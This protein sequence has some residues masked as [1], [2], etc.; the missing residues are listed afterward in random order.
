MQET[1]D[2]QQTKVKRRNKEQ[3]Q[4]VQENDKI[5]ITKKANEDADFAR[6]INEEVRTHEIL[7]AHIE[8]NALI[9]PTIAYLLALTC[10]T[11][12]S[13]AT[14]F[15]TITLPAH[16]AWDETHFG[17]HAN[18]YINGSFFFDVHPPLGKMLI[19]F[20]G[21]LTGYNASFSFKEPGLQ[22]DG[23]FY[24]PMRVFCVTLGTFLP[25]MVFETMFTLTSSLSASLIASFFV[26]F[27]TGTLTLS[28]Y[29][30]LDPPLLFF[31]MLSALSI[32]KVHCL[33]DFSPSIS[34]YFWM[35]L[36]GISIACAFSVKWVGAF[37]IL[38]VG[39]IT[40]KQLWDLI[41]NWEITFAEIFAY[42]MIRVILLIALPLLIYSTFFAIHFILLSNSGEGDGFFSSLFQTSLRGNPLNEL[43]VARYVAFGSVITLKN[44]RPAG[45]LLHS[46]Y[47][48]YP[49]DVGP[50]QQQITAYSHKDDNN[51]FL[52]KPYDMEL[53]PN[54]E[55]VILK[56]GDAIRLEHLATHRNLHSHKNPAPISKFHY[57]VS[58]YGENGTGDSNDIWI[59]EVVGGEIGEP[60]ETLTSVIKLYHHHMRCA[61]HSHNVQL[62][63]WGWEQLE[64]TC[65]PFIQ[66]AGTK[67]NVEYNYNDKLDTIVAYTHQPSFLSKLIES[68][69]VM[70][71]NNNNLKPKEGEVTSLPWQ[72]PLNYM[73]QH[74]SSGN[75]RVY[76]LGNPVVFWL[77]LILIIV[78]LLQ[79]GVFMCIMQR[80]MEI[81]Y[82][83][84][85]LCYNFLST[86][87]FFLLGWGMHYVPFYLMGRVLYFHHYFPALLFSCMLSATTLD[88]SFV[89]LA[90]A[91]FNK[92]ENAI[93]FRNFMATGCIA[94]LGYSF[95]LF[96]PLS[97]GMGA[98]TSADPKGLMYGLRWLSSWDF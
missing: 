52:I 43:T 96:M 3:R 87:F 77:N 16:V 18:N 20:V 61:L 78:Y 97:Y 75:H 93:L 22:Y 81:P 85:S 37:T 76:L 53:P 54:L 39:F 32:A 86:G 17:K 4:G 44:H 21:Y 84:K 40:I 91:I 63:K 62:P 70:A 23:D 11:V 71:E 31:I 94:I 56:S 1:E 95:Y 6:E 59:V 66:H 30:L 13:F 48:L 47:H 80:Q 14:R 28:Q 82:E 89:L 98:F 67:W 36:C 9:H 33:F 24:I 72:W 69:W 90:S 35:A 64:V 5:R 26:I 45:G 19:A 46:H 25:P 58:G 7:R 68:Q 41:G 50:A 49:E 51:L 83:F 27:D 73:G 55:P 60:V 12:C 34:W 42:F 79:L 88:F 8:K 92:T 2:S 57:Q 65:N 10:V 38:Y 29:I 74:F 15:H